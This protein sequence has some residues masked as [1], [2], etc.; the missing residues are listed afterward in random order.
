MFGLFKK[1]EGFLSIIIRTQ[2][3]LFKLYGVT[4]PT[5]AQKMKASVYICISGMAFL[6]DLGGGV[7]RNAIDQ[8]VKDTRE[9]TMPLSQMRV[10]D[11]ANNAEQLK[12]ILADLQV[13]E[14]TYVNGL[15][16][17]EA[18][19]FSI[20]LELVTDIASHTKGPGGVIWYA[21]MVLAEGVFGEGKAIEH[22]TEVTM[23]L[24]NFYKDICEVSQKISLI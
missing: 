17:F 24:T 16:A 5:D 13:T 8:L 18:L 19:Y 11:L 20:G 23:E 4:R 1:K 6:N 7:L 15:G 9:L 22:F 21:A 3:N 2:N 14:E 12:K 10:G